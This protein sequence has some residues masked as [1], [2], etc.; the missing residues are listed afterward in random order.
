MGR[1]VISVKAGVRPRENFNSRRAHAGKKAVLS[2]SIG[3]VL[4]TAPFA[5]SIGV[6][7][8]TMQKSGNLL[9]KSKSLLRV[10]HGCS[11]VKE[12]PLNFGRKIVPLKNNSST[13]TPQ[14]TFFGFV[15]RAVRPLPRLLSSALTLP[16]TE[17]P[18]EIIQVFPNF[19]CIY[20]GLTVS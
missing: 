2:L 19:L 14:N 18:G 10:A 16:T 17:S 5:N 7:L 11:I 8:M 9:F 3:T 12:V 13:K 20:H 6:I 4:P 1:Q 15:K